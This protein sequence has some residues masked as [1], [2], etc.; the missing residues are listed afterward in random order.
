MQSPVFKGHLFLSCRRK[1]LMNW[2]SLNKQRWPLNTGLT[3]QRWPLN[4]GLT[5]YGFV[6]CSNIVFTLNIWSNK[7]FMTRT[8]QDQYFIHIVYNLIWNLINVVNDRKK[9]NKIKWINYMF[10]IIQNAFT[11]SYQQIKKIHDFRVQ[12]IIVL[13]LGDWIVI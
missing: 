11:V 1:F 5:V 8:S 2:T 12:K 10:D 6:F 3:V 13:F 7:Y 4:T 9:I